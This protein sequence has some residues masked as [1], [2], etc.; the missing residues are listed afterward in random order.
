MGAVRLGVGG[1]LAI[2]AFALCSFPSTAAAE[3][4]TVCNADTGVDLV[5]DGDD[6]FAETFKVGF[7]GTLTGIG[8]SPQRTVASSTIPYV[9]RISHVDA[10]GTP[11]ND[12]LAS[13]SSLPN[14]L[15]YP[16]N[17]N[18]SPQIP[19]VAGQRYAA[20]L[21]RPGGD[22]NTLES[23]LTSGPI[24]TGSLFESV[25]QTGP[26]TADVDHL[27]L[28]TSITPLP[29]VIKL[30]KKPKKRTTSR[31]ARFVWDIVDNPPRGTVLFDCHLDKKKRYR[32][33]CGPPLTYK[34]LRPGRHRVTIVAR[35]T[36]GGGGSV[37]Y[38]WK[39]EKTD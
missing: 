6:R 9:A 33:Y 5:G 20:V 7:S 28:T 2:V 26:W 36:N 19:V 16:K 18:L 15:G 31:T 34:N 24:C 1:A 11:L 29:S 27:Y 12:V 39:I 25:G 22:V 37:T 3:L 32:P 35:G 8:L 21:T 23:V 30:T 17:F 38:K 13:A 4:D 14:A 10:A